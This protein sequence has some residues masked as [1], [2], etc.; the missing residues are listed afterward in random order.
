LNLRGDFELGLLNS[1]EIVKIW[2]LLKMDQ[3]H[4]TLWDGHEPFR[5]QRKIMVWIWFW[6]RF[7]AKGLCIEG[8][9]PI[10]W[11]YF[12]RWWKL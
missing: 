5:G 9:V 2:G 8:L 4:L 7:A 12:G 3:I 11:Y 1:I 10:W 6:I